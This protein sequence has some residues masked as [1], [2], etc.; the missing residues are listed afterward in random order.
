LSTPQRDREKHG[1]FYNWDIDS[2]WHKSL[3][4]NAYRQVS[5]RR[6][7]RYVQTI[8]YQRDINTMGELTT[9]GAFTP[10]NFQSLGNHELRLGLQYLNDEVEQNRHVDT[11]SWTPPV[12]SKSVIKPVRKHGPGLR[13]INGSSAIEWRSPVVCDSTMSRVIW[14]IPIAAVSLPGDWTPITK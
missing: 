9:D 3:E 1:V 12:L 8:W 7:Y 6:F 14:P 13:R 2:S 5:N 4:A 10:L 11:L